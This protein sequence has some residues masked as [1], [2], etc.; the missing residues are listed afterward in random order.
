MTSWLGPPIDVRPLFAG[1]HAAFVALLRDLDDGDW[2]RPTTC[3]GWDARD[4]ALHV[5]GDH[6][7]RLS[8][9]RDGFQ[10]LRPQAD[11]SFP[12]FIDRI[13]D[14]WVTA[15][16]RLS[17]RLLA[18]LL[19]SVGDEVVEFWRTVNITALGGPV[20]WAGPEPAPMWLDAARDFTEYW[21]HEQQIRDAVGRPG[22]D[23]DVAPV[24]DTFLRALPYTLR[25]VTAPEG[26]TL[27]VTVVGPG[28]GAWACTRTGDRW[29][30]RHGTVPDP[31]ARLSLDTDTAWRLCTRGITP[32]LAAERSCAEGDR[33]LT[34]TALRIVSIIWSPPRAGDPAVP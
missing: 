19:S 29:A 10:A 33:E 27:Q 7:G 13:N 11:E 24:I 6:V 32:A 4:I 1:R 9:L 31:A 30:L 17:P 8:M 18:G 28:E 25:G 15:G 16:R 12:G 22:L 20:T 23:G 34:T 5:L 21:T 26:T 3:P 14:E 2:A